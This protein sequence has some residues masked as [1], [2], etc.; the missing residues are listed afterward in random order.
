MQGR[1]KP[2][3]ES[4]SSLLRCSSFSHKF[5]SAKIVHTISVCKHLTLGSITKKMLKVGSKLLIYKS[6][7]GLKLNAQVTV[8]FIGK[9]PKEVIIL[10]STCKHRKARLQQP[11]YLLI[12]QFS[13]TP[14]QVGPEIKSLDQPR[15]LLRDE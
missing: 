11:G 8:F 2:N 3:A 4:M 14:R 5:T 12:N 15:V 7:D 6:F 10:I 9:P 1:C 13:G